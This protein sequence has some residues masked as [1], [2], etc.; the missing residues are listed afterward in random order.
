MGIGLP[1]MGLR[2]APRDMA[3]LALAD[4]PAVAG[5]VLVVGEPEGLVGRLAVLAVDGDLVGGDVGVVVLGGLAPVHVL[6]VGVVVNARGISA[7]LVGPPADL[8]VGHAEVVLGHHLKL[9]AVLEG[10]AP[11]VIYLVGELVQPLLRLD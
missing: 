9:P 4:V 10:V 6:P 2:P 5:Y 1:Q 11:T 7:V 8:V 3:A